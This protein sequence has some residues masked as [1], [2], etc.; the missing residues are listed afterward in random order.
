GQRR[1][2]QHAAGRHGALALALRNRLRAVPVA[3]LTPDAGPGPDY[4]A[5]H[6]PGPLRF[7]LAGP[8]AELGAGGFFGS[9]FDRLGLFRE[10]RR[11]SAVGLRAIA[12]GCWGVA[13]R[14]AGPKT[15]T[16]RVADFLRRRGHWPLADSN[17]R[18]PLLADSL[19]SAPA[20]SRSK[21]DPA[22]VGIAQHKAV[23]V[24]L[25]L[26]FTGFRPPCR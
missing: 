14:Q 24:A 2:E 17:T 1:G 21:D 5:L 7:T 10:A 6:A 26:L 13:E 22:V 23:L 4:L 18:R 15:P 20:A 25:T 16:A 11:V 9:G 8:L 3:G 19:R 12:A